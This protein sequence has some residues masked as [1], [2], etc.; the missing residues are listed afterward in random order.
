M[1]NGIVVIAHAPLAT[2]LRLGAL[3]VFAD[4]ESDVVAVDVLADA[5]PEQSLNQ[6]RT[7]ARVFGDQP[8]L[9][10]TDL[11]GATPSRI[12]GA[13]AENH[14]ALVL[15]GASLPML[16]RAMTY[17]HEPLAEMAER[18]RTGAIQGVVTVVD[19]AGARTN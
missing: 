7:A 15:A 11:M 10:L 4:R 8:L 2:A 1:R 18:A 16:L 13:L 12:A 6:A 17:Q 14:H 9:V 5:S 3:H 19:T